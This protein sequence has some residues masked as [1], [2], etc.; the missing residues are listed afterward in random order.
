GQP[1]RPAGDVVAELIA[2]L[3]LPGRL[4][5]VGVKPEQLDEIAVQSMHDRWVHTNP[6]KIEGPATVR[7]LL[8]AAW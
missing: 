6:R 1:G 7:R 4:R 3:G 2:A 8:D 5:D